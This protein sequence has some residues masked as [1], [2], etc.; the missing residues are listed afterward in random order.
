MLSTYHQRLRISSLSVTFPNS[1]VRFMGE[2]ESEKEKHDA[3]DCTGAE[4]GS[5]RGETQCDKII[6]RRY[7]S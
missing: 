3:K 7:R 5:V 2:L 1:N 4:D 6:R